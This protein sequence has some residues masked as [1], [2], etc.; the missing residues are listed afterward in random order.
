M[1]ASVLLVFTVPFRWRCSLA[2]SGRTSCGCSA[3]PAATTAT[4]VIG[5]T[6]S[7]GSGSS[8]WRSSRRRPG[9][10][11]RS[12]GRRIIAIIICTPTARTT[13]TRRC[14]KASGGRISAGFCR[15]STITTIRKRIADFSRYPGAAL[16]RPVPPGAADHLRRGDLPHRRLARV[17]LGLPRRD[18]AALPRHVPD[19]LAD[20]HLGHAPLRRRP[21]R[22][23]TTSCSR[24]SRSARAGTTTIT[25][26]CRASRQGIRWWEID[27]TYYILHD[28][29]VG[30][31]RARSAAVPRDRVA[32]ARSARARRR[33]RLVGRRSTVPI[34]RV[35]ALAERRRPG[36]ASARGR[37]CAVPSATRLALRYSS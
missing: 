26:S 8:A 18:R 11:A 35:S 25:T 15:T 16:A 22:A 20:A 31:H 7:I 9:R 6:S 33:A 3:S 10:R 13:C 27:I 30:R 29:V 21:T 1:H 19:Q 2:G 5:R 23:A 37:S 17:R 4:S 28:A 34:G 36:S 32:S 14:T 24:S 12:G